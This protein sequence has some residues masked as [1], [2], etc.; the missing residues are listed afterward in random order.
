MVH[1]KSCSKEI[2]YSNINMEQVSDFMWQ[3]CEHWQSDYSITFDLWTWPYMWSYST[4]IRDQAQRDWKTGPKQ[5][6]CWILGRLKSQ[7]TA[8][9][10][11]LHTGIFHV[12][13]NHYSWYIPV[14]DLH[15]SYI[16]YANFICQCDWMFLKSLG[17]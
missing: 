2:V 9:V 3:L 14:C 7:Y 16:I 8:P 12:K 6:I 4:Y 11:N 1:C 15:N 5:L 10:Y 17:I 13:N